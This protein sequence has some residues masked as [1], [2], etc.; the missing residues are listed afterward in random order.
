MAREGTNAG[1]AGNAGSGSDYTGAELS[2]REL[3]ELVTAYREGALPPDERARFDAHLAIC[4]PCVRYVEQLDL[5]IRALGGLHARIDE[6]EREA[7]TQELLNLFRAWKA[8]PHD[9]P[10]E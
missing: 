3:V 2:C 5:T 4:P 9:P 7:S 6:I 8:E 1:N 10:A